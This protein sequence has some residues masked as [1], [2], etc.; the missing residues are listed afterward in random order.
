M[1]LASLQLPW[2][3]MTSNQLTASSVPAGCC[4]EYLLLSQHTSLHPE[5]GTHTAACTTV[6]EPEGSCQ[7]KPSPVQAMLGSGALAGGGPGPITGHCLE[8]VLAA[9]GWQLLPLCLRAWA[10]MGDM[11]L[12][13][14]GISHELSPQTK[15]G[16]CQD[17]MPPWDLPTKPALEQKTMQSAVELGLI[18]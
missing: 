7:R 4:P 2:Y 5:E 15:K 3:S 14:Y 9:K 18:Y 13:L 11:P 17:L 16:E 6:C 8:A 12:A 1:A 10:G